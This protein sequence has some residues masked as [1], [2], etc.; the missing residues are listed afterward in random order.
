M[1]ATVTLH[2]DF[3]TYT[4]LTDMAPPLLSLSTYTLGGYKGW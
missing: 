1:Q 2:P 4:L 3:C